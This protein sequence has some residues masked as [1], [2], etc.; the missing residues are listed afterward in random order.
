MKGGSS[1]T[2]DLVVEVLAA[3]WADARRVLAAHACVRIAQGA[4]LE[5]AAAMLARVGRVELAEPQV[6]PPLAGVLKTSQEA[7]NT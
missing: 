2:A 7:D 1:G 3:E 4:V 5:E 6:R